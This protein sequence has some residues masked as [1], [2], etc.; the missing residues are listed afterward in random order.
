[1]WLAD[2]LREFYKRGDLLLLALCLLAAGFGVVMIFSATQY[3]D[4]NANV[5]R[6]LIALAMGVV[7]YIACS[8]VDID[9][10]LER[11]WKLFPIFNVFMLVWL[12]FAGYGGT[13]TGNK[14]W[15][16]IPGISFNLQPAEIT[17]ITFVML[18][19]VQLTY[20]NRKKILSNTASVLQLCAHFA[21]MAGS[22]FFISGDAGMCVAY[23]LIF[24]IMLWVGKLNLRWF[25]AG[26]SVLIGG[27]YV[28]Y[29]YTS[30]LPN[31]IKQRVAVV[32]DHSL[33]PLGIGYH[34]TR[35]IL[36]LGS[37]QFSGQ[38]LFQG[39]QSQSQ[40]GLPERHTDFIFAVIGEELGLLGCLAT[41]LLLSAIILRCFFV[42]RSARSEASSLVCVGFA[43]MLMVQMVLNIGMCLYVLP[44]IG[45]TLPFVSYGGSSIIS[46]FAAMGLVSSIKMRSLPSWLKDRTQ[47]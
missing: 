44:V 46:L 29:N 27:A 41:I 39:I 33:D 45:L 34:Q 28:V 36:A 35:G 1:M 31:Y 32:F 43:G 26:F 47:T 13:D 15:V 10:F 30:L 17:K 37:G 40:G 14:N 5:S 21:L 9:L 12:Y 8:F 25:V 3:L 42:S 24:I 23:L 6:Q 2:S 7:V 16:L 18:L 20:Y 38:G 19:A 11:G 22:I 4:T